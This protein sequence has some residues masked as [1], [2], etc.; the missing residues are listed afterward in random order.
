MISTKL[1]TNGSMLKYNYS[2]SQVYLLRLLQIFRSYLFHMIEYLE[3]YEYSIYKVPFN[4][5]IHVNGTTL[6]V[7]YG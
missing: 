6:Y 3:V 4:E 2:V 7:V 5:T 1:A